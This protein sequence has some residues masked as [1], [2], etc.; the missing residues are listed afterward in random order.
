M[1]LEPP[2]SAWLRCRRFL[3]LIFLLAVSLNSYGFLSGKTL[4]RGSPPRMRSGAEAVPDMPEERK[5][6]NERLRA[7]TEDPFAKFA[8]QWQ[9]TKNAE[10][11]TSFKTR[12]MPCRQSWSQIACMCL[13]VLAENGDVYQSVDHPNFWNQVYKLQTERDIY[14]WYGLSYDRLRPYFVDALV[15]ALVYSTHSMPSKLLV[16][17][18]GDSAL[19]AELASEALLEEWKIVSID[20]SSEVTDRMRLRFPELTFLTMDARKLDFLDASYGAI[21]DKGLSDCIGSLTARQQYFQELRRV[22][23][24]VSQRRLQTEQ[25]QNDEEDESDLGPHWICRREELLGALFVENDPRRPPFP[26]PGTDHTIP[27]FL[28]ICTADSKSA[29]AGIGLLFILPRLIGT[30]FGAP[31]AS[32]LEKVLSD[33][34]INF[35]AMIFFGFLTYQEWNSETEGALIARLPVQVSLN[36]KDVDVKLSDLRSGRQLLPRRPVICIGNEQFCLDCIDASQEVGEAMARCDFLLIPVLSTSNG[37]T[38]VADAAKGLSFVALPQESADWELLQ[39][40]QLAQVRSQGLD[41]ATG[42][43]IIVKKNGRVGTR[44]LG[45]PDWKSLTS[46][47]DA[48]VQIGLDTDNI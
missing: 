24:V 4:S 32:P 47:V 28:L 1:A 34:G 37:R 2:R 27:Y 42:Q 39:E 12:S 13:A 14:E 26:Q 21:V 18:S 17:G 35:V 36:G 30:L 33:L 5:F 10:D 7:E 31:R 23:L 6:S 38:S 43:A 20:F 8:V 29:G 19:S 48:R 45:V 9:E 15:D 41:E 16:V 25:D 3:C 40:I 44:F 22:R 11:I 46:E